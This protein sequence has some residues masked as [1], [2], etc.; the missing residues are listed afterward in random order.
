MTKVEVLEF[1]GVRQNTAWHFGKIIHDHTKVTEPKAN[2]KTGDILLVGPD[3]RGGKH[4]VEVGEGYIT[5]HENEIR[6][7]YEED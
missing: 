1:N 7:K 4:L 2:W 3:V 5:C 6:G